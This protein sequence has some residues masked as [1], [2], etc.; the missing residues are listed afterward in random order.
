MGKDK[1]T[2]EI[3]LEISHLSYV[4]VCLEELYDKQDE[5][6]EQ[7]LD[8]IYCLNVEKNNTECRIE[9]LRQKNIS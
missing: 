3:L 7:D 5:W 2:A 6:T 8:E 4:N 9:C 1:I